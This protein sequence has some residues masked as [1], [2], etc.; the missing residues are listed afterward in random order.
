MSDEELKGDAFLVIIDKAAIVIK[1][2]DKNSP[3]SSIDYLSDTTIMVWHLPNEG[4]KERESAIINLLRREN[5][6][7]KRGHIHM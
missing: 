2:L 1:R 5:D 4:I 6:N 7:Y 3:I